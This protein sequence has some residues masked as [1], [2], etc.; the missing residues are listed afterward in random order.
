[1]EPRRRLRVLQGDGDDAP[2]RPRWAW[3]GLGVVA[4]VACW[5]PLTALALA[6]GRWATSEL[7]L[8]TSFG[9]TLLVVSMSSAGAISL[10]AAAGGYILGRW[11]PRRPVVLGALSGVLAGVLAGLLSAVLMGRAW[12]A[13]ESAL[14]TMLIA[15]SGG[16][17]GAWTG[18]RGRAAG[19]A[20]AEIMPD[21]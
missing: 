2:P 13:G 21:G 14:P 20:G 6:A 3:V 4:I 16:A 10:G 8:G 19:L 9:L 12:L 18:A 11:G 7:A 5:V 15:G 1:M 17:L